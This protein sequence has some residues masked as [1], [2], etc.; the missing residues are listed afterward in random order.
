M[1]WFI[2]YGST[3]HQIAIA[4]LTLSR[5]SD[6]GENIFIFGFSCS[7]YILNL[8]LF[9]C[10]FLFLMFIIFGCP[11]SRFFLSL[12]IIDS[13]LKQLDSLQLQVMS[14]TILTLV[15]MR[16]LSNRFMALLW[17]IF[18]SNKQSDIKVY[19]QT[20]KW[21]NVLLLSICHLADHS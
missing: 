8:F 13:F 10:F 16:I 2:P 18:D 20:Q 9:F 21:F 14:F 5:S 7:F 11:L 15:N 1:N 6:L 4:D 17:S 12:L 19:S 3:H